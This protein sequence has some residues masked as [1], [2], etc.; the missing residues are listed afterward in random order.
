MTAPDPQERMAELE[1]AIGDYPRL[2]AELTDRVAAVADRTVTG[3]DTGGLV[4]V[5]A[6]AAGRVRSVRVSLRALRDLDDRRLAD[7][8]R[9]A[10]NA[11]L[12]RAEEMLAT[13]TGTPGED[14][15]DRRL[16]AFENRMD[17]LLYDLGRMDRMLDRFA[18]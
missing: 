12:E 4:T 5:T 8:V 9:E 7:R 6:T 3:E 16:A 1:H 13:A 14:D 18:D 11:A 15:V 10:A 2:V 17:D